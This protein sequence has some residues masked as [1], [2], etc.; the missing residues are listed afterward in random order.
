MNYTINVLIMKI[1][2]INE[3]RNNI[4]ILKKSQY[5]VY[6]HTIYIKYIPYIDNQL[7]KNFLYDILSTH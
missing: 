5:R 4:K 7:T 3:K 1:W 2:F 6:E